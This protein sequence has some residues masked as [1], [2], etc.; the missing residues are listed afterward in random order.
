MKITLDPQ[1]ARLCPPLSEEEEK[2]LADSLQEDGCREPLTLWGNHKN[3]L[4]DGHNRYRLCTRHSIKYKTVKINFETRDE[5]IAWVLRNQLGR[6]NLDESQ[7]AMLAAK[8]PTI[9]KGSAKFNGDENANLRILQE[10]VEDI[11]EEFNVS[12]RSI[13]SARKVVGDGSVALQK[14]VENREIAVSVA[15]KMTEL[16]KAQQT[17]LVAK[18]AEA[19][20]AAV[21]AK[22]DAGKQFT[23]MLSLIGKL[24]RECQSVKKHVPAKEYEAIYDSLDIACRE[25]TKWREKWSKK[26]G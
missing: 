9:G 24:I 6:R 25:I 7:R 11:A 1:F 14:A 22:P 13:V 15:A 21:G 26:A 19:A 18:G 20:R 17:K 3:T 8:M 2:M 10:T 16:P 4:L 23:N 5:A 12:P